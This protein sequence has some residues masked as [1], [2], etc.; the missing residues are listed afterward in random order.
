MFWWQQSAKNAMIDD[1]SSVVEKR[2][3]ASDT[4]GMADDCA[5]PAAPPMTNDAARQ[6]Y[7]ISSLRSFDVRHRHDIPSAYCINL[8]LEVNPAAVR[9][10][11][12]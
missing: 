8:G 12:T 11:D 6:R 2:E 1:L 4:R 10:D 7:R 3:T 9:K 5:D